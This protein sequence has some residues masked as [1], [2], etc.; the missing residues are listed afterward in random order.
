MP[1]RK[2]TLNKKEL[3][4]KETSKNKTSSLYIKEFLIP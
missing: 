3:I 4:G 1:R 2:T